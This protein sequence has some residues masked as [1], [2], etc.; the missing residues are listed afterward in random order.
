MSAARGVRPSLRELQLVVW[1][2]LVAP[3]G[4]AAGL[5]ELSKAGTLSPGQLEDWIAGDEGASALS[6]VNI[7]ANAYFFRIRDALRED[8][9]KTLG[10]IGEDRFHNLVTDYLLVRPSSHWSLRYAGRHLPAFLGTHDLAGS[11]PFLPTSP[12]WN[13]RMRTSSRWRTRR[14]FRVR[15]WPRFPP[16]AGE[17]SCSGSRP[18]YCFSISR[19]TSRVSGTPPSVATGGGWRDARPAAARLARGIRGGARGRPGR[20]GRRDPRRPRGAHVR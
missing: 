12:P 10:I 11:Y 14:Y 6:R 4:P 18:P 16:S 13:G 8:F 20:R 17:I 3:E 1:Q 5:L 15:S 19:G 9:P 2:L 7:Y